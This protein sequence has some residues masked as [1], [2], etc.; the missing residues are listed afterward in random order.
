MLG[1]NH[2]TTGAIIALTIKEPAVALPLAFAS[3]FVLDIIPHHGNDLRFIHGQRQY[4]RKIAFDGL[5]S[6]LILVAAIVA[7]P[8]DGGYIAA[9]VFASV[10][11]DLVWPLADHI[12]HRGPLWRYF[13]FHK[14]IQHESPMGIRTEWIWAVLSGLTLV[15]LLR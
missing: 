1:I 4:N 9:C 3:H 6:I 2:T 8:Q 7:R 15:S 10:L 5:A 11:P 14:G 12:E 13:K